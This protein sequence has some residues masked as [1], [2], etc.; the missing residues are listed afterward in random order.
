MAAT[1]SIVFRPMYVIGRRDDNERTFLRNYRT[2]NEYEAFSSYC[3]SY[4]MDSDEDNDIVFVGDSSLRCD[5]RTSQFERETRLKAYNLGGVGLIGV[6]GLSQ[7][8]DAYLRS[9]PKPRLLVLSILP[10]A[11]NRSSH[12]SWPQEELDVKSRFFWCSGRGPRTCVL[13]TRSCITFARASSTR[14]VGWSEGSTASPLE[15]IPFRDGET[16][17]TLEHAVTKERGFWAAPERGRLSMPPRNKVSTRDP[18]KVSEYFKSEFSID[19]ADRR[20]RR[21][22]ADP[23]HTVLGRGRETLPEDPRLGRRAGIQEPQRDRRPPRS[24]A[25]RSWAFRRPQPPGLQGAERFTTFVAGQVKKILDRIDHRK[26][27]HPP[28]EK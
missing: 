4:A 23:A 5:M 16:F 20:S 26:P 19:P 15:P 21:H 9:H 28:S 17:R 27:R 18:F 3:M 7:I 14:T 8:I 6:R 1:A 24:L 11:M 22:R 12:E 13:T 25:L 2:P 10:S